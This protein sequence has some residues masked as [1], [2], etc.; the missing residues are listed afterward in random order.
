MSE[1]KLGYTDN[2]LPEPEF[3]EIVSVVNSNSNSFPLMYVNN[4]SDRDDEFE[5]WNWKLVHY[6]YLQHQP[7][8]PYFELFWDTVV[9]KLSFMDQF[10]MLY[11][12]Y[13]E[14][15]P[16][17]ESLQVH[18]PRV[19]TEF[20]SKTAVL[21][22]SDSDGYIEFENGEKIFCVENRLVLFDSRSSYR[23]TT[24]TNRKT[25]SDLVLTFV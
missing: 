15:Y 20:S 21:F 24:T 4:V 23:T 13:V 7:S 18:Q 1:M 6:L 10:N 17:T 25:R 16:Y 11:K 5:N 12:A 14:V 22:L 3:D 19:N 9:N 8:S 2:F